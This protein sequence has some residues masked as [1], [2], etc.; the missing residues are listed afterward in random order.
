MFHMPIPD[1]PEKKP[2]PEWMKLVTAALLLG[3]FAEYFYLCRLWM[4]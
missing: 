2:A 1:S 3:L 4:Q